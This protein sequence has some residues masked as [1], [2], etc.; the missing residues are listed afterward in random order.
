MDV[1]R[2]QRLT[3]AATRKKGGVSQTKLNGLRVHVAVRLHGVLKQTFKLYA[4]QFV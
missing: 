2:A 1:K 4:F 3:A